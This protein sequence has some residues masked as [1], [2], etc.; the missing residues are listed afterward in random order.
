M[1]SGWNPFGSGNVSGFEAA[2]AG[3]LPSSTTTRA[4]SAV[5]RIA[6]LMRPTMPKGV[7]PAKTHD[8]LLTH[9]S[10][11]S[12]LRTGYRPAPPLE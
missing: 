2:C 5:F 6:D 7:G 10:E 8:R 1:P 12:G 9:F 4:L 11:M 3:T